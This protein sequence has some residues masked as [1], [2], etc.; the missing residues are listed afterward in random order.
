MWSVVR[1]QASGADG[2]SGGPMKF[3]VG[4]ND[5][6]LSIYCMVTC[7]PAVLLSVICILLTSL[8]HTLPCNLYSFCVPDLCMA[9][10]ITNRSAV[11]CYSA[12]ML[13]VFTGLID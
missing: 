8:F 11:D 13:M 4:K 10:W 5:K 6:D 3:L 12:I 9:V 2:R 7:N 1:V